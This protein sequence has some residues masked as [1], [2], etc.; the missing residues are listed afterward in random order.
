MQIGHWSNR[1]CV[2]SRRIMQFRLRTIFLL[3]VILA[4]AMGTWEAGGIFAMAGVVAFS[5]VIYYSKNRDVRHRVADIL[6]CITIVAILIVLLLPATQ[7]SR[8]SPEQ[9]RHAC[10]SRLKR[11]G[12]ALQNYRIQCG[13]FPPSHAV[14]SKGTPM[15]SWRALLLPYLG[16]QDMR[17]Q[18]NCNVPWNDVA[19]GTVTCRCIIHDDFFFFCEYDPSWRK[20]RNIDV[21]SYFAVVGPNTAW[22]NGQA[23]RRDGL[24]DGGRRAI[25]VIEAFNRNVLWKEPKDLSFDEVVAMRRA[26]PALKGY[27]LIGNDF[28]HHSRWGIFA[29]FADGGVHFI[30]DDLPQEQFEALLIGDPQN[31]VDLRAMEQAGLNWSHIVGLAVFIL[32]SSTLIGGA[33]MQRRFLV[34]L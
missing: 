33:I 3:F 24:P 31:S 20:P 25:Q 16:L 22:H 26:G 32:S 12:V 7:S 27:H 9:A 29:A 34:S 28:W 19:N 13:C 18:Y 17:G 4:S 8:V 14:D 10:L 5:M 11:I 21:A 23:S 1:D 30:P 6:V 2:S 15:H